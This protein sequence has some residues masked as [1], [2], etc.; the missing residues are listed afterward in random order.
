MN[1]SGWL[2][3]LIFEGMLC[4][5]SGVWGLNS[6]EEQPSMPMAGRDILCE[7]AQASWV[8]RVAYE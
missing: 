2:T 7:V 3:Y 8:G 4:A 6:K 1:D 5:G